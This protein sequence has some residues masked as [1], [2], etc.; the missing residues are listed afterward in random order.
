MKQF[1]EKF[2][3]PDSFF[4]PEKLFV[5]LLISWVSACFFIGV[6]SS[7]IMTD[8][9]FLAGESVLMTLVMT[10]AM[11]AA[12]NGLFFVLHKVDFRAF[13]YESIVLLVCTVAYFSYCL[14]LDGDV[15]LVAALCAIVCLC[16]CYA[17]EKN[18]RL[19][20]IGD[21]REKNAKKFV[22][23]F[24]FVSL[25]FLL[26][27]G[28]FRCLTFSSPNYDL[29]IFTNI[30][31][32]LKT[33]LIQYN[34]CERDSLITHFQV[35]VS[36]ILYLLTPI[37]FF[38]P[39]AIT[40]QV[41]QAM[42]VC[43]SVIPV[44]LIC[45][46]RNISN[47]LTVALCIICTFFPPLSTGTFY[48][49]HENAFLPALI[50]WMLYFY[51]KKR[52]VPM[53]IFAL[54]TLS[55][56]EDAS[57]YVAFF[58]LYLMTQKGDRLKG[59][60]LSV[61][62]VVYV[63]LCIYF[64][65]KYGFGAMTNRFSDLITDKRLGLISIAATV[66]L[67]PVYVIKNCVSEE[68]FAFILQVMA[69]LLFL[70]FA[71]KK[72]SRYILLGPFVLMNLMSTYKYQHS[73]YFQYMFGVIPLLTYTAVLN[74]SQ[75]SAKAKRKAV[76]CCVC[77]TMLC[78]FAF[79]VPKTYYVPKY[80]SSYEKYKTIS[81]TLDRIP[82]NVSVSAPAF[83]LPHLANR[84]KI[85]ENEYTDNSAEYLVFDLRYK[86]EKTAQAKVDLMRYELVEMHEGL[87]AVYR[88]RTG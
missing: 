55:V 53:F 71:T 87:I 4:A 5:R 50:L 60:A 20:C 65:N 11:F 78:F 58:G 54:L 49:F 31:Y 22:A 57:I 47:K 46:G 43:S 10:G 56:K 8:K 83:Y 64:I 39:S 66:I 85:Y 14:S 72:L 9:K 17:C 28:V 62:S 15:Y 88:V 45:K 70:P 19:F 24:A 7:I 16:C 75:L 6:K 69:P 68:K 61:L 27:V 63:F 38:F 35:H 44:Y 82:D 77:A 81:E 40:L 74:A 76:C 36:P 41:V 67:D 1:S 3:S 52:Y 25:C 18:G 32:N 30:A 29:G 48:D 51:E 26:A 13:E 34:T 86:Q 84:D 2:K 37:Y 59:L 12:V 79:V 73:I 33:K 42:L 80:F 21:I 23:V